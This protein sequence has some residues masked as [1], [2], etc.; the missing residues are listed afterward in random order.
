MTF[1]ALTSN[2]GDPRA[3]A[4]EEAAATARLREAGLLGDVYVRADYTGAVLVLTTD[5][6]ATAEQAVASL[7]LVRAG[8]TTAEIIE[9][10][11]FT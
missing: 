7:P 3:Y 11:P 10:L 8:V 4:D 2:L 1:L 9:V 6:R 5:D